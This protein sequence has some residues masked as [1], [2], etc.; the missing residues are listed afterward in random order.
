MSGTGTL[1]ASIA[2]GPAEIEMDMPHSHSV[3]NLCLN[4]D[5]NE[6]QYELTR[7]FR[8]EITEYLTFKKKKAQLKA[9]QVEAQKAAE[10]GKAEES[11][12]PS[13]ERGPLIDDKVKVKICD[14]GNGCW[15]HFHFTQR[16]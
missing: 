5:T 7:D 1:K 9:S 3:P 4:P 8:H 10:E 16:I 2:G 14:L 15:T 13:H 12:D 6:Y 11:K